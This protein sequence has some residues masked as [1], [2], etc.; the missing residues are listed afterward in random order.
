[1]L[2]GVVIYDREVSNERPKEWGTSTGSAGLTA[3]SGGQTPYERLRQ[4]T[5]D[6]V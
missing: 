4:K 2:D 1:M 5:R 6:P 3:A